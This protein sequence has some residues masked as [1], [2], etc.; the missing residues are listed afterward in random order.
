MQQIIRYVYYI[1]EYSCY[2]KIVIQREITFQ[3]QNATVVLIKLFIR[4][5]NSFVSLPYVEA[6]T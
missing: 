5:T 6:L 1:G 3:G 2:M 4:Y